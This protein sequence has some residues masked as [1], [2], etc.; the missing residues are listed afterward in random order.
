MPIIL[1]ARFSQLW[2]GLP[3]KWQLWIMNAPIQERSY[4]CFPSSCLDSGTLPIHGLWV[5]CCCQ[6]YRS[7]REDWCL[8]KHTPRPP[9][10]LPS[11]LTIT[12]LQLTGYSDLRLVVISMAT[13]PFLSVVLCRTS[14]TMTLTVCSLHLSLTPRGPSLSQKRSKPT[15]VLKWN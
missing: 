10:I 2:T 11:T 5:T 6:G 12:R 3:L 9:R 7:N 14:S 8:Q 15:S 1:S 13:S 4:N